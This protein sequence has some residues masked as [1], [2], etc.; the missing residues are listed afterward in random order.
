MMIYERGNAAKQAIFTELDK[1]FGQR[2]SRILDLACGD[3][4]LWKVFLETHPYVSV[5]GLDTDKQAIARGK[6]KHVSPQL[7]LRL[8]DAQKPF[9]QGGFDVVVAFSAIEHVVDR[10]AFLCTVWEALKPGGYAYLNYDVGHFRSRNPKERLMVPVSQLLAIIGIQGPYMKKV[11]DRLF[12]EQ[13]R[14]QGFMVEA[15]HKHNLDPLKGFFRGASDEAIH[16][17]LAFE[18][19]LNQLYAPEALDEIMWST[20]LTLKKP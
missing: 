11:D 16:A 5:V 3:G 12:A 14:Q 20:T 17:W 2:S 15:T 9:E 4:R 8:L 19:Q 6:Q 1:S 13:A 18:G 10:Q 7:D